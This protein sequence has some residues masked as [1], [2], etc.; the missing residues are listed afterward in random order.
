MDE[1]RAG[2]RDALDDCIAILMA[3]LRKREAEAAR[4]A[5]GQVGQ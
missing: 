1:Y 3:I 4:A 5:S 2:Y